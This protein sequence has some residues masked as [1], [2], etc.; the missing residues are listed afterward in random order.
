MRFACDLTVSGAILNWRAIRLLDNPWPISST[1][2]RSRA[3]RR[4][5]ECISSDSFALFGSVI[6]D[7]YDAAES[8]AGG[9]FAENANPRELSIPTAPL[10]RWEAPAPNPRSAAAVARTS[11]TGLWAIVR[12]RVRQVLFSF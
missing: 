8:D 9:D 7:S 6:A 1:I 2:V 4:S 3:D 12:T 10:H 11:G 5:N